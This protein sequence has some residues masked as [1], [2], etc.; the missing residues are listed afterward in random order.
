M[1]TTMIEYKTIPYLPSYA[2]S[3]CGKV[4]RKEKN[5]QLT[6][7]WVGPK[8]YR[9][10]G[11]HVSQNGKTTSPRIHKLVADVWLEKPTSTQL[12]EVN[13]K[14]G[15]KANNCV[16]NLQ[17]V[18]KAQNLRHAVETGLKQKGEE[19]Y[20]SS[21]SEE[22]VH[23]CCKLLIDGWRVKDLAD[24]F[25]ISKDA[26]RKIRAGDTYFHIRCLYQIQNNY[27]SEFSVPTV[28]WVCRQIVEG[29]SDKTIANTSTNSKLTIIDVKRIRH[30]IRYKEI[31]DK[32]F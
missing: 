21:I 24:K 7:I 9:Y 14:D 27:I 13:H 22:D 18:T 25:N 31:S 5:K 19:L 3:R 30:K 16:D 6:P 17:W 4:I 11:V 1:R 10:L 26:V 29:V 15:D 2:V 23:S 32:Y 8:G 12:L 28:E 20:N